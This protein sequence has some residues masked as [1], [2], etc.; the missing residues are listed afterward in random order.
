MF[1]TSI[2][3]YD[4]ETY[5]MYFNDGAFSS[6]NGRQFKDERNADGSTPPLNS[7]A[8]VQPTSVPGVDENRI[9]SLNPTWMGTRQEYVGKL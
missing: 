9:T 1:I 4:S 7:G 3:G 5:K 8:I 6:I 2:A